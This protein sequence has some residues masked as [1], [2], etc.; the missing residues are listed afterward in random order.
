M[1]NRTK[2]SISRLAELRQRAE[3]ILRPPLRDGESYHP[4]AV[5][6]LIYELQVH[7]V[8]LELQNEELRQAQVQL[9]EA[10]DQY[11][12]A[13]D[14]YSALYDFAPVGY[15]TIGVNG[16][17]E[18]ANLTSAFL[19][20]VP[21]GD[22]TKQPLSNFVFSA[23]QDLLYQH[24]RH[25]F[26]DPQALQRVELRLTRATA[27]PFYAQLESQAISIMPGQIT[28]Y[29][30][31][32]SDITA[33]K[34]S[35]AA[36][37]ASNQQLT[38]ALAQLH[39]AQA[40]LLQQERLAAVGQLAAG[41][42]HDFNNILTVISSYTYLLLHQATV[43]STAHSQLLIIQAQAAYAAKLVQQILDFSRQSTTV[44]S[45]LDLY[46]LL[47]N[48]TSMI[49]PSLGNH[50]QLTLHPCVV[51]C[52]VNGNLTQLQQ[53]LLNLINNA[54]E[55]MPQGGTVSIDLAQLDLTAEEITPST[56]IG[57]GAWVMLIVTDSGPGIAPAVLPHIFEP[58]FTTRAPQGTGLGLAQVHGIIKQHGGE[59]EVVTELGKGTSF[60]LYLPRLTGAVVPSVAPVLPTQD[61]TAQNALPAKGDGA[62]LL[63]VD[64]NELVVNMLTDLLGL[65]GYQ[66]FSALDGAAAL[67]LYQQ[68][69]HEI[70]L[71]LTDLTMPQM[72]GIELTNALRALNP[73]VKVIIATGYQPDAVIKSQL[74]GGEVTWLQ[75]PLDLD[76]LQA[77]IRQLIEAPSA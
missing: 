74:S 34:Q 61:E 53:V 10:R 48:T 63:I 56:V 45:P 38:S 15:M 44:H 25:L 14:Q 33:R 66:T 58:F 2:H 50:I 62:T 59:I 9:T 23:D 60:I 37:L 73:Q 24:R 6:A 57:P 26:A 72:S 17:I 49:A 22:L 11:S 77:T 20:G 35:E 70:A 65:V 3:S 7:Q 32:I 67:K 64:D 41:I 51:D 42:A 46:A 76:Q 27:S 4:Q 5:D 54:R 69:R 55:V 39:S 21:R 8:E 18:Q 29:R 47:V 28:G 31:I 40:T 36:L 52:H 16:L 1:V 30:T 75:K 12:E 43:E 71:V 13:R 19:L 68:H